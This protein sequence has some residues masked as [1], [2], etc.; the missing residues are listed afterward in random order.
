MKAWKDDVYRILGV[1][2]LL[3]AYI[4]LTMSMR[5]SWL[6]VYQSLAVL[7]VPIIA[8]VWYFTVRNVM[9]ANVLFIRGM[10]VTLYLAYAWS[11]WMLRNIY[12]I[13]NEKI[14]LSVSWLLPALYLY[15]TDKK[16]EWYVLGGGAVLYFLSNLDEAMWFVVSHKWQSIMITTASVIWYCLERKMSGRYLF[17]TT[18]LLGLW[19]VYLAVLYEQ[20]EPNY[21]LKV[22]CA[23]FMTVTYTIIF[24][25]IKEGHLYKI[26]TGAIL[27]A[28]S[29]YAFID[30]TNLFVNLTMNLSYILMVLVGLFVLISQ[31]Y[32]TWQE[33][34]NQTNIHPRK[35][36]E[37][38][39]YVLVS[40]IGS[41]LFL[42]SLYFILW[43]TAR[44]SSMIMIVG[45][46]LS[47]LAI[48]VYKKITTKFLRIFLFVF[49]IMAG[50]TTLVTSHHYIWGL[51]YAACIFL[52]WLFAKYKAEQYSLWWLL[53]GV[54]VSECM[55]SV[56]Y[57]TSMSYLV[58]IH[59][60]FFIFTILRKN[61]CLLRNSVGFGMIYVFFY[62]LAKY[63][64]ADPWFIVSAHGGYILL[65]VLGMLYVRD[66]VIKRIG[67]VIYLFTNFIMY[68]TNY[69]G[70][71][72]LSWMLFLA[73][74][75]L[76]LT[77]KQQKQENIIKLNRTYKKKHAW[78]VG[79]LSSFILLG[80][81]TQQEW[82]YYNSTV[83]LLKLENQVEKLGNMKKVWFS[84]EIEAEA[85]EMMLN[86]ETKKETKV[87]VFI[88]LKKNQGQGKDYHLDQ[89]KLGD[90]PKEKGIW[91]KGYMNYGFVTI[92]SKS[93]VPV[94]LV[95][96]EGMYA[97]VQIAKNGNSR[98]IGI[99]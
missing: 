18:S 9:F 61:K 85:N 17:Y 87:P 4:V 59:I 57:T 13:E 14:W 22:V 97:K 53:E 50:I 2:S 88:K 23:I 75:I 15:F 41:V 67:V 27:T 12:G 25:K 32:F 11:C 68:E 71:Y 81:I 66:T 1:W 84:L 52:Y 74:I 47:V 69:I 80:T 82:N 37:Y 73:G 36:G 26:T 3:A 24:K 33:K 98:V 46:T 99:Q 44:E 64:G 70:N 96:G 8:I 20:G 56:E 79:I 34:K 29:L 16:T 95:K 63:E 65:L 51:L 31:Q 28:W 43:E 89:I 30:I 7:G 39:L 72:G 38:V 19:M 62:L 60:G 42:A 92:G 86:R 83:V 21:W 55:K 78:L 93:E 77:K 10:R 90:Y 40:S 6:T 91:I 45:A 5:Y 94:S 58:F 48:W 35:I 54:I 49:G 76:L